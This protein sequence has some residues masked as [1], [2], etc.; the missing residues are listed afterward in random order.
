MN[1]I[2]LKHRL[3]AILAADV[4]GYSKLMAADER[5]TVQALDAGRAV[6][7]TQ[8]EANGGR[9]IDMAGDSVLAVFEL[10]TAA[11]SAAVVI[12][13]ALDLAAKDVPE[14]RRMR[15]RIGVHL[16][17]I[18]EK[19]DGTVYGDGVN[20]AAR[21][22][23]LAEPGGICASESVRVAVRGKVAVRFD[24]QGEQA[25]KNIPDPVHAFRVR[26]GA[27]GEPD[28]AAPTVSPLGDRPSIAV[29]PFA[30]MSGDPEQDYFAEGITEDIITDLARFQGIYVIARNSVFVYRNRAVRVQD[31]RRD[32]GVGY[33]V[34]GSVRKAATRVRVNVQLIDA[35]SGK[36]LWAERYDRELVDIFELQDELTQRIVA[37][38]PSRVETAHLEL[39]KRKPPADMGAYDCV[40]R[41]K[42]CHHRGTAEDNAAALGLLDQAIRIDPDHAPAYGW[43]ACTLAQAMV[44]G[45]RP[46]SEEGEGS[47][48]R[49]VERGLAIDEND[50]ECLRITCEFRIEHK[51]LDEALLLSDKL[52]RLNPSD[53]R[54]LAQRG[55]ILTWRGKSDEGVEW[56]ERAMRLDP[57]DA[58]AW[59]HLLGRA[60]FGAGRY[61]EAIQAFKRVPT[62]RYGH[63]AYLAACYAQLGNAVAAAQE[64]KNVL[65]LKPDFRSSDYCRSLS[66]TDQ[67][68][69]ARVQE[70]LT[71]AGLPA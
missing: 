66:Y 17:E 25:V 62:M 71:R 56:I 18:F 14:D 49:D 23:G 64:C 26:P 67:S 53:P 9:V 4:S 39:L 60:L 59:A 27:G 11:V 32:L 65:R 35:Q 47:V 61:T 10:A 3:A 37:T 68:H 44:R 29:L 15:F 33:V 20:I 41:A 30:N 31:V 38:L 22:E 70:A 63:H 40:L 16:G 12:Q 7:R 55:E 6:F 51:R 43:R 28:T 42:L 57:Q 52:L 50:L 13:E 34:E 48:S 36:H 54:L 21:L 46:F 45:F 24:D 2:E 19:P 69:C 58:D 8:I 5:A 1:G